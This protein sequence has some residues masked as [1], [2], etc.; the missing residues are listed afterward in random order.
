MYITIVNKLKDQ[1]R[2]RKVPFIYISWQKI[3]HRNKNYVQ[4]IV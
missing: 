4:I 3:Q 1:D 2:L